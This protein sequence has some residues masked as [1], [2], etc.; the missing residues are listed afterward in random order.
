MSGNHEEHEMTNGRPQRIVDAH[1]HLWDLSAH[2]AWYPALEAPAGDEQDVGLGE[3][4]GL[5]RDYGLPEYRSDA[6]GHEITGLVHVSA[7]SAAGAHR[8]EAAW[9][10]ALAEREGLPSVVIGAID[11]SDDAATIVADLERQAASPR[12]RGVRV[13]YGLEPDAPITTTLLGW[14]ER[15][16]HVLDLVAHPSEALAWRRR[17]DAHP[18]LAVVLEHAGWPEATDADH[19]EQWRRGIEALAGHENLV[20]KLSGL[21]MVTHAIEAEAL[22]P[23]VA[24][25]LDV[26]G[27][28]RLAFGSNFPVE[29][30]Y[31]SFGEQVDAYARLLADCDDT[32]RDAIFAGTAERVY[33]I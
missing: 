8:D 5:R 28:E 21:A 19:R 33:G 4:A 13:L 18:A 2:R 27:P 30:L 31:G 32:E 23:W 26:F 10:D 11:P 20:C 9:L 12:F 24:G 17:L 7:V 29:G 15:E 3:M 6:A 16:G 14:L 1:V 25:C 22:R